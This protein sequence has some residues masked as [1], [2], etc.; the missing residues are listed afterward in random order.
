MLQ[1]KS[2]QILCLLEDRNH[3]AD[4]FLEG[5]I[6]RGRKRFHGLLKTTHTL[7]Q[8][9]DHAYQVLLSG[10][11]QSLALQSAQ[12]APGV[13]EGFQYQALLEIGGNGFGLGKPVQDSRLVLFQMLQKLSLNGA[14]QVLD[15]GRRRLTRPG[16][17]I[18]WQGTCSARPGN[19]TTDHE[20][21]ENRSCQKRSAIHPSPFPFPEIGFHRWFKILLFR[22]DRREEG[23]TGS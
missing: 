5:S 4:V 7:F 22:K 10:Q 18:G 16:S 15:Q 19:A 20:Y 21:Q 14:L 9:S 23:L 11:T 12:S 3:E 1:G 6:L 13:P 8:N 17:G 2:P